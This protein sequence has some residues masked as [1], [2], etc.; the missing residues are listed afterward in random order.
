MAVKEA[1]NTPSLKNFFSLAKKGE[2]TD[3]SEKKRDLQDFDESEQY[4]AFFENNTNAGDIERSTQEKKADSFDISARSANLPDPSSV[5]GMQFASTGVKSGGDAREVVRNGLADPVRKSTGAGGQL[6]GED[7]IIS[8]DE[9]NDLSG[10][11]L[12]KSATFAVDE[13]KIQ[14]RPHIFDLKSSG[15]I[16]SKKDDTL[17]GEGFRT[18]SE[19]VTS[20]ETYRRKKAFLQD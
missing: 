17:K 5:Q 20:I 16:P 18:I 15:G 6:Q 11:I 19:A 4:D 1:E 13:L 8:I 7:P 14:S 10:L 3:I 12:P 9:I 2:K